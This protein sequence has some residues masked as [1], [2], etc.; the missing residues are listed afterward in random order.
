MR[1]TKLSCAQ[2]ANLVRLNAGESLPR[3]VMPKSVLVPL[4][5]A[6]VVQSEKS[7]SSY[8]VRGVPGKLA[9]FV[10]QHWGIRDL[11]RYSQASPGNRTRASLSE[12]AGDS[13][14]LPSRPFDGIFLRSF[15]NC[16]LGKEPLHKTPA[17][18]AALVTLSEISNLRVEAPYLIAVENAECLWH[19]ERMKRFFPDL[20]KLQYALV[21][22]WHWGEPWRNWL[23][24]W[25]G[26]LLYIP[27]Y[28]PAGLRIFYSEVRP[29]RP[30]VR[31]LVADGLEILLR[32]RGDRVLFL[33][34]ERFLDSLDDDPQV[35]PVVQL[36]R[37]ARKA[38]EQ[39]ALLS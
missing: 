38:L 23:S 11:V 25:R 15:D 39:E 5:G 12:I 29:Q 24:T 7:G 21:L 3:S 18:T 28:D 30:D 8:V 19:F 4:Q 37:S 27:D 13:K 35:V 6:G 26:Q 33:K 9:D 34:Q 36:L 17:G 32:E 1:L 14:A 31:L 16:F 22:R 2:A 10:A 20:A